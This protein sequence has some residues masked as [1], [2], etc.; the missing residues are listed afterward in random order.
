MTV[1]PAIDQRPHDLPDPVA[2]AR[3]RTLILLP[4]P[5]GAPPAVVFTPHIFVRHRRK[6]PDGLTEIGATRVAR[7][8]IL[9]ARE[10]GQQIVRTHNEAFGPDTHWITERVTHAQ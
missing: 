9:L 10:I 3:P 2:P 6:R 8:H 1:L 4:P 5:D 7:S